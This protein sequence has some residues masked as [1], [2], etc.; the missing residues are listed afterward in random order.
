MAVLI[1]AGNRLRQL[2]KEM[3]AMDDIKGFIIYK[4]DTV[5]SVIP[6]ADQ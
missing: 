2:V 5:K 4:D 3:E 6:E 1:D